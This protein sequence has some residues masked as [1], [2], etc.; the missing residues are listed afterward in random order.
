[1][2][3][4]KIYKYSLEECLRHPSHDVCGRRDDMRTAFSRVLSGM[5]TFWPP[6]WQAAQFPSKTPA[7]AQALAA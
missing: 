6:A 3:Q 4:D 2:T 5:I 7:P 1:M